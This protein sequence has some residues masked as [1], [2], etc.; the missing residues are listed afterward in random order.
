MNQTLAK[1]TLTVLAVPLCAPAHATVLATSTRVLSIDTAGLVPINDAGNTAL[2]FTTSADRQKLLVIHY[3]ANCY[4]NGNNKIQI[5]V[6]TADTSPNSTPIM[7]CSVNN[8][9]DRST[10]AASRQDI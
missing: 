7:F 1:M 6:D 2:A 10:V 8:D 4:T 3:I 5:T 9:G